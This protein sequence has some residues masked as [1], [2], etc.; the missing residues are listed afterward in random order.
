MLNSTRTSLD[1]E[2]DPGAYGSRKHTLPHIPSKTA[3]YFHHAVPSEPVRNTP[4]GITA[5][6][7]HIHISAPNDSSECLIGSNSNS[8]SSS[9]IATATTG[10]S[11]STCCDTD[12][13]S[14]SME[15]AAM[16]SS[17]SL[18]CSISTSNGLNDST[19]TGSS[20][21]A[22]SG[23]N[24]TTGAIP[25]TAV[26]KSSFKR[27]RPD[28]VLA[29]S[30]CRVR[31]RVRV[32][33]PKAR[34]GQEYSNHTEEV[35]DRT[36]TS[37]EEEEEEE[38]I[39]SSATTLS[40]GSVS[41]LFANSKS[42]PRPSSGM[43]EPAKDTSV[44]VTPSGEGLPRLIIR[45]E[46][47]HGRTCGFANVKDRRMIN[48]PLILQIVS[49]S[50]QAQDINSN[51]YLCHVSLVAL[52]SEGSGDRSAALNS[53]SKLCLRARSM[54]MDD[55]NEITQADLIN[56]TV[57]GTNIKAPDLLI[58]LNGSNGVFFIFSDISVRVHGKYRLKC[59]LMRKNFTNDLQLET[60]SITYT[61]PFLMYPPKNYPGMSECTNLSRWFSQQ[62]ALV[63]VR[64]FY[65]T[66]DALN[67]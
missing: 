18:S 32:H 26:T 9:T 16:G 46:P 12:L 28:S 10:L 13:E 20:T 35:S 42:H 57:V 58:D 14:T 23:S 19:D 37:M 49:E 62:G 33:S 11:G 6:T 5:A 67:F 17:N 24:A 29:G 56:Q 54:R 55:T 22:L 43:S 3:M 39:C 2:S 30:G 45:Q 60:C 7:S 66:E 63:S 38:V 41:H 64:R 52:E 27:D 48:P 47:V 40:R 1:M 15:E 36:A 50:G 44:F 25:I 53:R 65:V 59:Q 8:N 4:E 34:N 61:K 31:G 21:N 51:D